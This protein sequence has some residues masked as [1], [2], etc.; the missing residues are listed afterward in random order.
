MFRYEHES[1]ETALVRAVLL[2][3]CMQ[4]RI[5]WALLLCHCIPICCGYAKFHRMQE[6]LN[7]LWLSACRVTVRSQEFVPYGVIEDGSAERNTYT[8]NLQAYL[9][10]SLLPIFDA[11]TGDMPAHL[12][13][14]RVLVLSSPKAHTIPKACC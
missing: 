13:K 6:C 9:A 3:A 14:A 11:W 1:K 4:F 5:T 10:A 7:W 2:Q 12:Q 8:K